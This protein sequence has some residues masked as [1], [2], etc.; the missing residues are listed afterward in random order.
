MQTII[1]K[2]LTLTQFTIYIWIWKRQNE[3]I[4]NANTKQ[5][6]TTIQIHE[7]RCHVKEFLQRFSW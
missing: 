3:D 4:L 1:P 5:V 7:Q 2:H 6:V